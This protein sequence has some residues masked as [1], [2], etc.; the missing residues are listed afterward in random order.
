ML[1]FLNAAYG[2]DVV[3]PLKFTVSRLLQSS[4]ILGTT[5]QYMSAVLSLRQE[6]K[7][8]SALS[9]NFTFSGKVKLSI[10]VKLKACEPK[11]TSPEPIKSIVLI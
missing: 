7:I 9:L 8:P 4:N 2:I 6:V 10:P 5:S 11:T 3:F 1:Q